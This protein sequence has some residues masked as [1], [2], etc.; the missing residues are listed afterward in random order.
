[1]KD[2]AG[3]FMQSVSEIFEE[4]ENGRDARAGNRKMYQF[5]KGEDISRN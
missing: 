1:M 4:S 5:S 2:S 3:A